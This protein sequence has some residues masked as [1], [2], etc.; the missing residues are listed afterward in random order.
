[1]CATGAGR[2]IVTFPDVNGKYVP[3]A[4]D[5]DIDGKTPFWQ[6]LY[7]N[8]K[9]IHFNHRTFG[10][11]MTGLVSLQWLLVLK[12]GANP[13]AKLAITALVIALYGQTHLGAKQITHKMDKMTCMY[14]NA[15]AF[16]I[17][18]LFLYLIHSARK[19]NPAAIKALVAQVTKNNPKEY[20]KL[21]KSYPK[22]MKKLM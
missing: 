3:S 21:L 11:I 13:M 20:E 2:S 7:E 5:L 16:L 15:N 10:M 1:M 4:K 8:R 17:M 19:P 9:L 6:E 18:A 12:S 14:H 22:Q